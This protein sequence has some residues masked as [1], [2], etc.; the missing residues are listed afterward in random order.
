MISLWQDLLKISSR[1]LAAIG[2]LLLNSAM[3][4][5]QSL[6]ATITATPKVSTGAVKGD[7][8]DP[9][10][11]IHPVDPA[12]SVVIGTDKEASGGLYVWNMSGQQ[13]QFMPLGSPNNVDVR[14]G[15][16]VGGQLIDIAVTN[17][18]VNPKQ[19]KVYK[20]NS[21]DG[22]LT[23]I[24]TASGILTPQLADP[25]GVCLY[26]RRSDG[27]MF[28]I[29]STQ[30]GA[31]AN[32][33]QYRLE[34]DGAGKVKGTYVRAI[35]NNTIKNFVEGLVADDEL[36]YVYASDEPNAIRKYYADPDRGNND[37][38]VAFAVGDG[39]SGDREGLAIY[40]CAAG[41]GYLLLSNQSGTDV[42]VYRREGEGG[43]PHKHTLLTTIKTSGSS[44]TDGL[45]V[46]NR[47]SSAQFPKGFLITHNAPGKQFRLYAWE[48]IAQTYLSIC[49]G[50][51]GVVAENP[52]A[53]PEQ[54]RLE[55]NYPNPFLSGAQSSALGRGNS[56]TTI[57]FRLEIASP[58]KLTVINLM[59]Q[60]VRTLS[61]GMQAAGNHFVQWD[62]RNDAGEIVA[63]GTYLFRL[64][65]GN[66]TQ[67]KQLLMIK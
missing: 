24:T 36:G 44:A 17:S 11:W 16:K 47:P 30:A 1:A 53:Q 40:Q 19:I 21:N 61:E 32:L 4:S 31:T 51:T 28:V 59:G 42:K 62:G 63:T 10:I 64:E 13:I 25:Y 45:D 41:T 20:I 8:D 39:I 43:D 56:L 58:I 50:T 7:A 60:T 37:Q 29:Q 55:Q 35:G 54:F 65:H 67:I 23:D 49:P 3:T 18:R 6:P 5:A 52:N 66:R 57:P 15:M 22:T 33:H 46:T 34:D 9:A 26:Q 48:D 38:I 12:K 2:I 14:Y 27:A